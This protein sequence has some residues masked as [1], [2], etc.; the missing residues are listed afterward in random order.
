MDTTG[1]SFDTRLAV[2]RGDRLTELQRV[3]GNDDATQ[4]LGGQRP[5]ISRV[6]FLAEAGIRYEIQLGGVGGDSGPGRLVII[7]PD[8]PLPV[9]EPRAPAL[10]SA[11]AGFRLRGLP[12]Q[13][14]LVEE[15]E[16]LQ[17]WSR[18][19]ELRFDGAGM[20]EWWP[21]ESSSAT[22]FFRLVVPVQ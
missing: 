12:G 18:I 10:G 17:F 3:A 8:L 1:S 22:R 19:A 9:M 20:L 6:R 2:Y 11:P 7:G 5:G 13:T 4:V 16:N 21:P 15:S 14:V